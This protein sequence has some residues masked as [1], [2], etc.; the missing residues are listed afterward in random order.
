MQIVPFQSSHYPFLIEWVNSGNRA[1]MVRWAGT[2][3]T[4][5]LTEAQLE[6]YAHESD[7]EIYTLLDDSSRPAGHIALRRIDHEHHSARIGKI[8][9]APSVRGR[10]CTPMMLDFVLK[11]AFLELSLHR[12]SLGVFTNNPAA[13]RIYENYGFQTEGI[14]RD[15]R[16]ID[17]YYWDLCEMAV[18]SN[19][20]DRF[21]QNV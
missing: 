13:R 11:R 6:T 20:F 17:G 16:Y 14:F 21:R 1:D 10:G 2:T 12:V 18:L 9:T 3:F 5:P 8:M 19:E 7:A 4:Y 15:V